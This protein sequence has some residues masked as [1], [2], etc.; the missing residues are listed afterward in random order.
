LIL[1]FKNTLSKARNI[2]AKGINMTI[3]KKCQKVIEIVILNPEW[4]GIEINAAKNWSFTELDCVDR[5]IS[6]D[7]PAE[8]MD[9]VS[10]SSITWNIDDILQ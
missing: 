7:T 1:S 8:K 9:V 2:R 3:H 5:G 6:P 10:N 4:D